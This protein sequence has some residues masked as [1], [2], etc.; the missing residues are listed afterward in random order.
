[1]RWA[2]GAVTIDDAVPAPRPVAG[3]TLRDEY[4]QSLADLTFG[5]LSLRDDA[6]SLGPV[7]L[8]RF[9]H[10]RTDTH[11][12]S[13]PIEGGLLAA[14]PGG[15]LDVDASDGVIVATVTGYRPRLPRPL[16][17][18]IQVPIHHAISTLQLRRLRGRTPA[19]GV[20]ASP[21]L[22]IAAGLIDVGLC[23]GLALLAARRGR[24]AAFVAITAGYHLACWSISGRT[25]G[26]ALVGQR[27]VSVDGSRPSWLQSALRLV[28][29]P[30]SAIRMRA[31]HDEV[32]ATDVIEEPSPTT[33]R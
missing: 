23:A 10:P 25:V 12:V 6:L 22:R 29:V 27:V 17:E 16:Y 20:P 13:W 33:I 18:A 1:M 31:I 9:G 3:A 5:I 8:I 2:D 32:A 30:F 7:E 28:T 26:G 11:A 19:P 21:A 15:T 24:L 4:F 14:S